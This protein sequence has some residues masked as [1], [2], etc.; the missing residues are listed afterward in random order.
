MTLESEEE[1]YVSWPDAKGYD[2]CEEFM[3]WKNKDWRK[4][5]EWKDKDWEDN[6]VD[7]DNDNEDDVV[8]DDDNNVD[9][10]GGDDNKNK[11]GWRGNHGHHEHHKHHSKNG[12][13]RD[14]AIDDDNKNENDVVDDDNNV[15]DDGGDENK[16]NDGWRG[17]HEHHKS[18]KHRSKYGSSRGRKSRCSGKPLPLSRVCARHECP[19]F[20]RL[21]ISGCGFE[22]RKVLS[23]NW[24]V[25]PIDTTNITLGYR[26][27]FF[28]LFKYIRGGNDQEV[29]IAMT[30]PVINKWFLDDNYQV[31][32]GEMAF[33]IPSAFQVN[34]PIPTGDEVKVDIWDD[35]LTYDRAFGG[36]RNDPELYTKEFTTLFKAL[37]KEEI[38]PFTKMVI[39][40]GYT[41]PGWGRQRNE[42]IYVDSNSM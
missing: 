4:N 12:S 23:A 38:A 7:N 35:A 27:A 3:G 10:D 40:A 1:E 39:T 15:D 17:H 42:V 29:K 33:F 18:H 21:N 32:G 28:R 16:N 25:T 14:S 24:T 31:V 11:D 34:P 30:A 5:K 37:A 19:K 20:E 9:D 2:G 26:K 41:R 8:V 36:R 13:S 6:A 22:A